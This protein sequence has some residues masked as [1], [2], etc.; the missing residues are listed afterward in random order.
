M[1]SSSS[2]RPISD[3]GI[4][5]DCRSA[6]LVGIDG[7]IE[8]CCFPRFD[9]PSV[10]AAI[11]DADKGGH[12]SLTPQVTFTSQQRYAG[13]TNVLETQL[14]TGAGRCTITDCMP[15]YRGADGSPVELH[16]IIRAL[17]CEQGIVPMKLSYAPRPDYGR[18]PVRLTRHGDIVSVRNG[19]G[20]LSL[21]S[22]VSLTVLGDHAESSFA[23]EAGQE[24]AFVVTYRD[25]STEGSSADLT[26]LQ[27]IGETRRFWDMEVAGLKHE[28]PWRKEVIRSYLVLHLLTHLPTGGIVASP[29]TSLPEAIRGVR[30]WDY[31]YTW[32]RDAAFTIDA[33]LALGHED[34]AVAFFQWLGKVCATYG[35][36]IQILYRVDTGAEL[37]EEELSHLEGYRGS[38][39]VRIG[40]AASK[41]RQ[42]DVFGEVLASAHLLGTTCK[43]FSE[44]EWDLLRTL[45]NLAAARWQEPDS[46][47]WEVRSGPFHFL[48]SKL[49][50]WV[51]LDRVDLLARAT[52]RVGEESERWRRTADAI[53][54]DILKRGWSQE[55]QA[56]VQHYDSDAMDASTLLL[57]IMG[58]LPFD[59]PR[60]VSTVQRIRDELGYGPFLHRYR[61]DETDDGLPGSEGAFTLCS[62]W[63]VR[64]LAG[65]G[66][67]EEARSLF[68][69]LLGYANHLGLFSEMVDSGTGDALGNFPQAFTHVG[70]ILAAQECGMGTV[71]GSQS[72]PRAGASG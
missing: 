18:L 30:N 56:F 12:F 1:S 39:P 51:A 68:E 4:I 60:V 14:D 16:Q 29:T 20:T 17:R 26:P 2:Y 15:L 27:R 3:Y 33:L 49:M 10:F 21:H 61:T 64:V 35:E 23:L 36:D 62:F 59:D 50:C 19:A 72:A 41:Q 28:G 47:I 24:M 42:N 43:S 37:N 38:S 9:S 40:N 6:A 5:G 70:L 69:Q 13:D 53:K 71:L 66:K 57:P 32:L 67:L 45:A 7:S 31:R 8:W 63:L 54:L 22:P 46:G 48:Y 58:L 25:P 44:E 65:M 52:G 11:L 55:K 34:E